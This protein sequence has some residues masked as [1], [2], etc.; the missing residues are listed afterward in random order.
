MTEKRYPAMR[1][2]DR[3]QGEDW[4]REFITRAPFGVLAVTFDGKPYT[5][6]HTFFYDSERHAIYLHTSRNGHLRQVVEATVPIAVCWSAALMGRL[7]PAEV[8][9]EFSV[10]YESVVAFGTI[11]VVT[12]GAE[13]V[14]GLSGLNAKYFPHLEP[15]KDYKPVDEKE[16]AA[17]TVFR[18]DIDHWTGKRKAVE[19]DF[20][21]AFLF[22]Q[23][24]TSD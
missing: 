1:R 18:I 4:I 8:A 17:T 19:Q 24:P 3:E 9:R 14:A 5:V 20:P 6:H 23:P 13:Q 21:G 22:G 16:A 7:L 12:D 2:K 11:C 15:G 10:E